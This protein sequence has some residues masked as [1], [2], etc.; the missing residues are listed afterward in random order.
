MPEQFGSI[1][2]RQT[3]QIDMT[4]WQV[5]T[6]SVGPVP[7]MST[8]L[9]RRPL[10]GRVQHAHQIASH[11]IDQ[12][13]IAVGYPKNHSWTRLSRSSSGVLAWAAT[14]AIAQLWRGFAGNT[15]APESGL[16]GA[17]KVSIHAG[18]LKIITNGQLRF[19]GLR[20]SQRFS[21]LAPREWGEGRGE[22]HA[23]TNMR[24]R[25]FVAPPPH[26]AL[27]PQAGRGKVHA[28]LA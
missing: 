26:P 1:N 19:L 28:E 17:R 11:A 4:I 23:L 14:A 15:S 10:A 22:G 7:A 12:N 21:S 3:C 24:W 16:T 18:C 27:S 13:V 6:V 2:I 8:S 5:L 9:S 25:Q 20:L